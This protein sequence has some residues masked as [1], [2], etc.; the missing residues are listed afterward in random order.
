MS[1][2]AT[3][4][5]PPGAFFIVVLQKEIRAEPAFGLA[6]ALVLA[7]WRTLNDPKGANNDKDALPWIRNSKWGPL[8]PKSRPP[9][10]GPG[11][12][13][14]LKPHEIQDDEFVTELSTHFSTI[15]LG[16][17]VSMCEGL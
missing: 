6:L 12:K 13:P 4:L 11:P 14:K 7:K 16:D 17:A 10:T 3:Q 9:K 15:V 1:Q 8:F 2:S 5:P